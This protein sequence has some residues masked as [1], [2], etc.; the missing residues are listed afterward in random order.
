MGTNQHGTFT[1]RALLGAAAGG[2]S[3]AA[4]G[5]DA[6]RGAFE[7]LLASSDPLAPKPPHFAARAKRVIFIFMNG[8]VSHGDSFD[9]TGVKPP[10]PD[11]LN[12]TLVDLA[13]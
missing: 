13:I 11:T 9:P 2:I 6:V 8:G 10:D 3:S 1:R 12:Q 7:T 4:F 5:R